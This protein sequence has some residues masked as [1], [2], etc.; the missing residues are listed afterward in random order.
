MGEPRKQKKHMH[1]IKKRYDGVIAVNDNAQKMFV[2]PYLKDLVKTPVM[3]CGVNADT[4][5]YGYNLY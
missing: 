3:F 1:F 4:K 5:K 2:F